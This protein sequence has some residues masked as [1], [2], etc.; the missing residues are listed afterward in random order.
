MCA[1]CVLMVDIRTK[2]AGEEGG[3]RVIKIKN[4]KNKGKAYHYTNNLICKFCEEENK[5]T[6]LSQKVNEGI[7]VIS[8]LF[9]PVNDFGFLKTSTTTSSI[10]VSPSLINP[11]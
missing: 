3:I 4:G 6:M 9:S 5:Y 7:Q 2:G 11:K 8:I 1:K 10:I